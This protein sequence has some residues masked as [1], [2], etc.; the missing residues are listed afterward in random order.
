MS[1]SAEELALDLAGEIAQARSHVYPNLSYPL[2]FMA[3]SMLS[4]SA[5]HRATSSQRLA[6][7]F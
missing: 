3:N 7:L 2:L 6:P 5:A 4:G 1:G